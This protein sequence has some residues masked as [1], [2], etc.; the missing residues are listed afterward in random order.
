ML[1]TLKN[2]LAV[3]F[4]QPMPTLTQK[5][6][7]L[8]FGLVAMGTAVAVGGPD[9]AV[10]SVV[11]IAALLLT[12]WAKLDRRHPVKEG[13][14][15][16]VAQALFAASVAFLPTFLA[17]A[18]EASLATIVV[19]TLHAIIGVFTSIPQTIEFKPGLMRG[20][21]KVSGVDAAPLTAAMRKMRARPGD[22]FTDI[23]P[24]IGRFADKEI[25]AWLMDGAGRKHLFVSV[26]SSQSTPA[27][28]QGESVIAPGLLYRLEKESTE[29]SEA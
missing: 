20:N 9:T 19:M 7:S 25:P 11:A 24:S 2:C 18:C 16:M 5:S 21:A 27:L 13:K 26:L 3:W 4:L 1:A 17:L 12:L 15:G 29:E 23:G 6:P 10:V 22:E 8:T 14:E 28:E